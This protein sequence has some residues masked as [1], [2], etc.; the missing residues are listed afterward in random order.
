MDKLW[1]ALQSYG[2]HP[3]GYKTPDKQASGV[4]NFG[5]EETPPIDQNETGSPSKSTSH[6]PTSIKDEEATEHSQDAINRVSVEEFSLANEPLQDTL[7]MLDKET[8][9]PELSNSIDQSTLPQEGPNW[10]QMPYNLFEETKLDDPRSSSKSKIAD[11]LC[12]IVEIEG[13]MLTKKAY[14]IYLRSCGVKRLGRELQRTM[15]KA[16]QYAISS[17]KVETEDEWNK[18]G[19]IYSIVRSNGS[20]PI[21]LRELG[22]RSFDEIPPSELQVASLIVKQETKELGDEENLRDVLNFYN[23][24]RLTTSVKTRFLEVNKTRFSYV[25]EYFTQNQKLYE[26][27]PEENIEVSEQDTEQDIKILIKSPHKDTRYEIIL[28]AVQ[29]AATWTIIISPHM[30]TN[31]EN[32]LYNYNHPLSQAFNAK[33]VG[34]EITHPV[35]KVRFQITKISCSKQ[36]RSEEIKLTGPSKYFPSST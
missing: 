12:R 17:G 4:D 10:K 15:N 20:P 24:K 21:K 2:I 8:I 23:L 18:G 22:T 14:D 27:P 25:D 9:E 30:V 7:D 32:N 19:I 35:Y 5:S 11:G 1:N 26:A 29:I 33:G 34:D 3:I 6:T 13:P 16:M 36:T 28:S 31:E